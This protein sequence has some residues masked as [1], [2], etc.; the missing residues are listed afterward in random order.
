MSAPAGRNVSR[1]TV[2]V[3]VV[4]GVAVLGGLTAFIG[5][6]T[7][8][9]PTPVID[10]IT[11]D[12]TVTIEE[13]PNVTSSTAPME[14]QS[15]PALGGAGAHGVM[16]AVPGRPAKAV[17][18]GSG[19][20]VPVAKGW[21]VKGQTK[22]SVALGGDAA[23]LTFL[24]AKLAPG[25]IAGE[26]A[27]NYIQE[28]LANDVQGLSASDPVPVDWAPS[29]VASSAIVLYEGSLVSQQGNVPVVGYVGVF[30]RFD[31]VTVLAEYMQGEGS[32]ATASAAAMVKGTVKKM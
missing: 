3:S 11:S 6:A 15:M 25:L 31:G 19:I 23:L 13:A 32:K 29:S 5:Q 9:K 30:T 12:S 18:I 21:K 26:I 24:Q 28:Q 7:G 8:P 16:S 1:W 10:T 14:P 22:T 2:V 27:Q 20:S 4:L 17:S